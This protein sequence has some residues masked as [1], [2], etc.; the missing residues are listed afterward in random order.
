MNVASFALYLTD[1]IPHKNADE[2]LFR[3]HHAR[4]HRGKHI[5]VSLPDR[6]H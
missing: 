6:M 2:K 3:P 1:S 4:P 5:I